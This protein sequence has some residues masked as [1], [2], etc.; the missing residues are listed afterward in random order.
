MPHNHY[1]LGDL[2]PLR[3]WCLNS[4]RL[5]VEPDSAPFATVISASGEV[6]VK[7]PILDRANAT[8]YFHERLSLNASYVA[9]QYS[10]M[11]RWVIAG[12]TYGSIEHFTVLAGGHHEGT[13]ISCFFL[14]QPKADYVLMQTDQG[15]VKRMLNPEVS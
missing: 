2:V 3:V 4:S 6:A 5:P 12:I 11:Y 15:K 13:G 10:V 1:Q 7:L 14:R 9:G 8:G